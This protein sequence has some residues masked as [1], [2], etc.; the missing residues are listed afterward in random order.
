MHRIDHGNIAYV[1]T[2]P[3]VISS[4]VHVYIPFVDIVDTKMVRSDVG[5]LLIETHAQDENGT[6][7]ANIRE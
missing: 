2:G 7:I 6:Y 5:L 3:F 4:L 1:P